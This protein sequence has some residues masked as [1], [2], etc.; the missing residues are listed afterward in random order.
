M[1]SELEDSP[2]GYKRR[3]HPPRHLA[4]ALIRVAGCEAGRTS[5]GPPMRY[6]LSRTVF[7]A[8]D[9]EKVVFNPLAKG[10]FPETVLLSIVKD[11]LQSLLEG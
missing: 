11:T 6:V 8:L 2:L 10:R 1:T 5:L 3:R 7:V 4:I 9:N